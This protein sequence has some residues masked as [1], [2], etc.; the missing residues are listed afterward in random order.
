[1]SRLNKPMYGISE[2]K[3]RRKATFKLLESYYLHAFD[4][5]GRFHGG[6]GINGT[7][8]YLGFA[9]AFIAGDSEQ[10]WKLANIIIESTTYRHCHFAPMMTIQLLKKYGDRLTAKAKETLRGYLQQEID[11]SAA[12]DMDFVGVNDNFPCMST[13]VAL[14][15]G[16]LLERP[17][18]IDIGTKRLLQLR[19]LL[20][21][22]GF[23]SEFNSPTYSPIQINA[24]AE[25]V[26]HLEDDELKD[27]ALQCEERLWADQLSHLHLPTS[28]VAGPYSRAYTIDSAGHNSL[29]R[30]LLYALLGN[31]L[32]SHSMNTLFTPPEADPGK[33]I[34][35][36]MPG[37]NV[38]AAMII[39]TEY[40]CPA[41]LVY[42]ML[43]K[44]YPYEVT[45]TT[46][47]SSSSD[48]LAGDQPADP[49]L[50]EDMVEYPAGV[51]TVSTFMTEEYALGTSTLEFHNGVQTDS[52]HFLYRRK[53]QVVH[54]R[55]IRTVYAKFVVNDKKPGQTNEYE[56]F[57]IKSP[58]YS[59]W[60]EGR[61]LAFQHK[62]T[63]MVLYKP[64]RFGRL[65]A[66]SLKLSLIFPCQ[67]DDL[68]EIWFG[69]R[70]L[71]GMEGESVD[72]CSV[73]VKDGSVYMAFHT[74]LLTNHGRKCAVKAEKVNGYLTI[75]F[76]NYE[77]EMKDFEVKPYMLTG[78]GFVA[79]F[80]CEAEAGGFA[81]FR[82][83]T[84][85]AQISDEQFANVHSR[86]TTLRKVHF[87][88]DG[89]AL[90]CEYS[91]VSEGVKK[92]E[93]NG[94]ALGSDILSISGYDVSRLPFL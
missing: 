30:Y 18:L 17:D 71:D 66:S 86:H 74:L 84:S 14:I 94:K 88:R 19:A 79:E 34:H 53:P 54:Q 48:A 81:A 15:G 35:N 33:V 31:K 27:I 85:Q 43:N 52:F 28:Q 83:A 50:E 38:G 13:Y 49:I 16:Q 6:E 65:Q 5:E 80:G 51:G 29:S 32:L 56:R 75:S 41:E 90:S 8:E 36:N 2:Q 21:R 44:S 68:D 23:A 45:G 1:M 4:Q 91:P 40:H 10:A 22:R 11:Q 25:I 69:E 57:G 55:D 92:I 63:A 46:E 59:L 60:D 24:I 37:P 3:E 12:P 78:N 9:Q 42:A 7:R 62:Q 26:N 61:K 20:T 39:N 72:P 58:D 82:E 73:Y 47:F 77:G 70:K 93:I 67:Y 87:E 64:K 89:V 76:Y